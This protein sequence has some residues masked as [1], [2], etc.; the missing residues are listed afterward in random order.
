MNFSCSKFIEK[1][2]GS[3]RSEV[4]WLADSQGEP[5]AGG[6]FDHDAIE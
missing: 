6:L 4:Y 3:C 1:P 2:L 5:G